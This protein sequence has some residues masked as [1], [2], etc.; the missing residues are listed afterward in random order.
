MRKRALYWLLFAGCIL[1]GAAFVFYR[2]RAR[3]LTHQVESPLAIVP[4]GAALVLSLDVQ[5]L[6]ASPAGEEIV[7]RAAGLL[8]LGSDD[9][10]ASTVRQA[11]SL[12]LAVDGSAEQLVPEPSELAIIASG[13]FQA[14]S[15][16]R[17]AEQAISKKKGQAVRTALGSFLTV[18][19]QRGTS[20]EVAVR[21]AG[22]LVIS[23]GRYLRDILDAADGKQPTPNELA[24]ARDKLHA[25]LRR[26]FGRGAPVIATITLPK[27]WLER[28]LG[29]A[30]ARF[31]PFSELRSVA[32]RLEPA[33]DGFVLELLLSHGSVQAAESVEKLVNELLPE[34]RPL[35]EAE[36]GARPVAQL[37]P[38]RDGADLRSSVH[39]T[40]EELE[41]V[42]AAGR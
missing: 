9:C 22:P 36:L 1:A 21:D 28:M 34:V 38:R 16:V 17:C 19:D 8:G 31:S 25:E 13:P 26:S 24:R 12:V 23:N 35:L 27:G 7:K 33:G 15:V 42:F 20:G 3:E 11:R 10:A 6:A 37:V 39:L 30:D 32:L 29:D 18:R 40:R 4:P 41:K 14:E 2:A 5:R